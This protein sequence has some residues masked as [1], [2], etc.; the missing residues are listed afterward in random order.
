M[1]RKPP[2]YYIC[3]AVARAC[4]VLEA[5]RVPGEQLRLKE[6]AERSRLSVSTA[7][8]IVSTLEQRGLLSRAG[9]RLYSLNISR[10]NRARYRFGYAGQSQEFAFSRAVAESI[11]H[12]AASANIQMVVVDNHYSGKTAVRNAERFVR[13]RVDLV[14]EFQTDEHVAPVISAKLIEANIPMVAVEIPHPGAT[15][16]GANNY[17]AGEIGGRFLGRWAKQHWGGAVDEVLLLELPMA[18]PL[19]RSRLVGTLEGIRKILPSVP[20]SRVFWIDG[21]GQ[22]GASLE[23]VRKHLRQTPS[24]RVLIGGINDPSALG[25]LRAFEEAGRSET[26]AVMGQN[27]SVEARAELRSASGSFV[28]SVAY[29]PETYGEGLIPLCVDILARKPVPPAVFVHHQLVT[30]ENVDRVYPNDALMAQ[31]QLDVLLLRSR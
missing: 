7:F 31:S 1:A 2:E 30:R 20:D 19:P 27:A 12:A 22:F 28:G 3:Q 14:I 15:Y 17:G 23:A 4:D 21:K 9:N 8:R 10:P 13:E 29:F 6:L 25:A 11:V 26:C 16:Y 5:F 18:G 24:R